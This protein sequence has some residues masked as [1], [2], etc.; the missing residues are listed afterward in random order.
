MSISM[1]VS[2][3][4]HIE[5]IDPLCWD[6]PGDDPL[7][8]H[9]VLTALEKARLDGI[10]MQYALFEDGGGRHLASVPYARLEMDGGRLTHGLFR[11]LIAAIR[12][13]HP[14][15]M[16]TSLFIC[17]TPLSVGNPPLRIANG[18]DPVPVLREAAGLLTELANEG[19]VPWRA[20]KEFPGGMLSGAEVL[21]RG[22]WILAP[23]EPGWELP[24]RWSSYGNYL[25][26]LRSHYRYKIRKSAQKYD[27]AGISVGVVPL[28]EG[29]EPSMHRLYEDVVDR[30]EI[31]LERLSPAFFQQLGRTLGNRTQII[32]FT[33]Q[34]RVVGW[35][36][37]LLDDGHVHDL[38]HG[39]DYQENPATDIYFNQLNEV[40]RFAIH[41][42][43][44]HLSLGQST[45]AAKARFGA[46]PK[47][48]WIAVRHRLTAVN[49][50]LQR[51]SSVLFPERS[52]PRCRVFSEG[53]ES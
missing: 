12:R 40:I 47:P 36:A 49:T 24:I 51:G 8:A 37:L 39:I 14:G 45:E 19:H 20:F 34:N 41:S 33:L 53:A 1:N 32:R 5:E 46:R 25:H 11:R 22:G 21:T 43:G 23:S 35:V 30:A 13:F 17:G 28:G 4:Q 15:F 3:F 27:E 9:G 29:Y 48:L 26:S 50:L 52:T 18:I 6:S 42:G 16:Q 10:Q 44:H 38:F 7:S 2:I 31:V